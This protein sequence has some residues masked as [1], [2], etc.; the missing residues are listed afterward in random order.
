MDNL[1][2]KA[3]FNTMTQNIHKVSNS[4]IM[5]PTDI[6][7]LS[8]YNIKPQHGWQISTGVYYETNDKQYEFSA[9]VYTKRMTDYL[10]Y[11]NSAVLLMNHHLETDVIST[12]GKAY[13]VEL[14]AK[15]PTGKLNGWLSYTYSRTFLRQEDS[16][17]A[18]LVNDGDWFASE[19]D[20][21]H[22]VKAVLNYKFTERYSLSGNF[23]YATGRPTTIPAGRYYNKKLDIY[24]P[25]YTERN[26][27]RIPDYLRFDFAFNIEPTHKLTSFLHTSF[28]IGAYNGLAR[29]NAYNIYYVTEK[30]KVQG[31]KLSVF[32]S[33]I[34]YFSLNIRLN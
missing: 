20:R 10:S 32:G 6:W 21:P 11:R 4:T 7:K 27:Y 12:N 14:Q 2:V 8:D 34:P 5:S 22:E 16:R 19:Y 13:G 17:A 9:E 24:L 15:K 33:I 29:K 25:Y 30:T 26:S 23:N 1:S 3:G 31:Y 28:S 18:M